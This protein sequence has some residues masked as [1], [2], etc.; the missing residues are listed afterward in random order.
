MNAI[1]LQGEEEAVRLQICRRASEA[2]RQ[3]D[4]FAYH[5]AYFKLKTDPLFTDIVTCGALQNCRELVDLGCGQGLLTAWLDAAR[6]QYEQGPWPV[7][8]PKPPRLQRTR[9]V[10]LRID[11]IQRANRVLG[12]RGE[13][14]VLDIRR[15][16]CSGA[17]AVAILDV[18]HYIPFDEQQRLLEQVRA[19][20]PPG[21]TL[22]MR[23]ANAGSGFAYK[24]A[25]WIDRAN[26]LARDGRISPFFCRSV[27]QWLELL[28]GLRFDARTQDDSVGRSFS[29]TVLIARAA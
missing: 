1:S 29:N 27:E 10:D 15:A 7:H 14:R 23:V 17:D 11:G 22:V 20:L 16:D 6:R 3:A 8:W 26:D 13:F 19:A 12:Q 2:Y 28:R 21:G 5:F 9:G 18:V 25:Q 4:R 24:L